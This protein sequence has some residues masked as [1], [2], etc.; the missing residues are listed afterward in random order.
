M[1]N[2]VLS[3]HIDVRLS[4]SDWLT[5]CGWMSAHLTEASPDL[6]VRNIQTICNQVVLKAAE[7]PSPTDG[8]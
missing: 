8:E 6:V 2:P 1:I 4:L 3:Q 7:G 5:L